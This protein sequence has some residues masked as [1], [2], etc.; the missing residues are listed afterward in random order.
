MLVFVDLFEFEVVIAPELGVASSHGVGGFQQ[1]VAE[2]TVAGLDELS[3][4]GL[5]VAG[6]VLIPD[7]AGKLGDGSLGL[8]TVDI[9]DFGDDTSGIDLANARDGCKRVGDCCSMALSNTLIWLFRARMVAIET[10]MA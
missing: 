2:E 10:D 7:K 9:A 3:V 5:E 8:E 4:L 6:L 1:I